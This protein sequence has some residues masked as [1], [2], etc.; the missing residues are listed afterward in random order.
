MI[1]ITLSYCKQYSSNTWHDIFYSVYCTYP[2]APAVIKTIQMASRS[3]VNVNATVPAKDKM[4]I[5]MVV[6]L[7]Y[8]EFNFN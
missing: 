4:Y 1:F 6:A 7:E 2:K 3:R 8:L 5:P